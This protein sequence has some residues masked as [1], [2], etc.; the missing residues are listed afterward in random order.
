MNL[1]VFNCGSSSL[2][3]KVFSGDTASTAKITA[4]GKA[5]RVG[6]K[7]S[8]PSFIEHHC[9]NREEKVIQPFDTH[10]Q[11][12]ESVLQ[13]LRD[14]RMPIDAVG[15]RFVHGGAYFKESTLLTE[16]TFARLTDCLQLAPI[17]NPNSMSVIRTCLEHLPGCPQYVTFDTAFH[18]ALPPEAYTYAVPQSIRDAHTYRRF[19]FH[20]LSY[21][22]VTQAARPFLKTPFSESKI[23]ACHL[24]TGGS[25][26]VA[27]NNGIPLDTSMGFT[28]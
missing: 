8:E 15:H 23:I 14:H 4:K 18:A 20:G 11:A 22:Y 24:G 28:P 1:L 12:A 25:S 16:D 9:S 10:A 5:H 19:G 27:I 2:N 3:Y 17:H 6:V 26:A 21:Q 7:G 13:H